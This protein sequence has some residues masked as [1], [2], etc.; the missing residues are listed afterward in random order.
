VSERPRD[1]GSKSR[2]MKQVDIKGGRTDPIEKE[3]WQI[4]GLGR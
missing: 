1:Q 3:V 2:S 4:A